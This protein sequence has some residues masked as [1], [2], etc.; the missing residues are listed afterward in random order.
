[1]RRGLFLVME[2]AINDSIASAVSC[3][4]GVCVCVC[5]CFLPLLWSKKGEFP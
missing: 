2:S 4:M 5:V 3:K 1:M